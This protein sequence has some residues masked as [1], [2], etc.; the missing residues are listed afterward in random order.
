MSI[1][2][3][4]NVYYFLISV[5]ILSVELAIIYVADYFDEV[6][7][8]FTF[9]PLALLLAILIL[10][11]VVSGIRCPNCNNVYGVTFML[12]GWP[13]TS[14]KCMHC[15]FNDKNLIKSE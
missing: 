9:G 6:V 2:T 4:A 8:L 10:V 7:L 12:W 13:I 3:K 14:K 15:G 1:S 11:Y 5:A